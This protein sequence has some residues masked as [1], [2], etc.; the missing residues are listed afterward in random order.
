MFREKN[1][2]FQCQTSLRVTNAPKLSRSYISFHSIKKKIV[3]M[4]LETPRLPYIT[5]A[6]FLLHVSFY[7]LFSY[8]LFIK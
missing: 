6:N 2:L 7:F 4:Y 3:T 5:V 1:H 8:N